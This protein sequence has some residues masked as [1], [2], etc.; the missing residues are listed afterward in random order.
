MYRRGKILFA[1]LPVL[2][3]LG[4][5]WAYWAYQRAWQELKG[6]ETYGK[7]QIWLGPAMQIFSNNVGRLPHNIGGLSWRV[8]N[9]CDALATP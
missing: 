7:N 5:I 8:E 9:P 6:G 2:I 3:V 4:G 1:V